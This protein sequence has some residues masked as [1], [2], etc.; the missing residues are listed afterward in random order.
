MMGIYNVYIYSGTSKYWGY[1]LSMESFTQRLNQQGLK[2]C[3]EY[4]LECPL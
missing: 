4:I 1:G 3:D 2:K